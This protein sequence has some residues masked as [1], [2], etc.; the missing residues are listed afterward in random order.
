MRERFRELRERLPE[1]DEL[2]LL[3]RV[4]RGLYE[5][6]IGGGI[7]Q[8]AKAWALGL[9]WYMNRSVRLMFNYERTD[10]VERLG[11]THIPTERVFLQRFQLKL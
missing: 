6:G 11:F 4:D 2:I 1:E 3:L 8:K 10:F 9:N 5:Q 7:A